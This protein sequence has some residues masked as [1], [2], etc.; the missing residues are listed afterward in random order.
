MSRA[1]LINVGRVA[2]RKPLQ[3][4]RL[5]LQDYRLVEP[6]VHGLMAIA[7]ISSLKVAPHTQVYA[8]G[9]SSLTQC[10]SASE[11]GAG[12]FIPWMVQNRLA[13]RQYGP[14]SEDPARVRRDRASC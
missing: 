7:A 10:F 9:R 4:I 11:S 13:F 3:S 1:R 6:V 14:P 2:R 5:G 8:D 12:G